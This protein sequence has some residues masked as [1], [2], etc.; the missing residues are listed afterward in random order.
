MPGP[1]R[2]SAE[3]LDLSPRLFRDATVDAS[4]AAAAETVIGTISIPTDVPVALGV[5]VIADF[6]WTVGTDGVSGTV[7]IRR[8]SVSGTIVKSSGAKTRT[9]AQLVSDT[10]VGFDT[11]ASL[12]NEVYVVTLTVGSA[13][14][15]STVSAIDVVA[16]VI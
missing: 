6:A 12:P 16:L 11:G 4:P 1:F 13:S 7:R 15:A 14:A 8:D 10:I 5:L 3:G 9:A 2:L